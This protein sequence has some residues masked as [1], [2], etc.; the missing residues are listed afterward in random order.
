M[1]QNQTKSLADP[2]LAEVNFFGFMQSL[3]G[4]EQQN[5]LESI[6]SE[7]IIFA[8]NSGQWRQAKLVQAAYERV[9]APH[10]VGPLVSAAYIAMGFKKLDQALEILKQAQLTVAPDQIWG[11]RAFIGLFMI[12]THQNGQAP[13]VLQLVVNHGDSASA[14]MATALL[15]QFFSQT[16]GGHLQ[17]DFSRTDHSTADSLDVDKKRTRITT[18]TKS[19]VAVPGVPL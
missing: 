17:T 16:F 4:A 6:L 5:R 19:R 18:N 15:E 2:D 12:F 14:Q 8:M 13:G 11:L 1:F 7:T 3:L 9:A 10:S